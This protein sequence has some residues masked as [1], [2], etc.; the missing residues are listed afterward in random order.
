[1]AK[2]EYIQTAMDSKNGLTPEVKEKLRQKRISELKS[3][4]SQLEDQQ[5]KL[6]LT[7]IETSMLENQ[8]VIYSDVIDK[9]ECES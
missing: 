7:D 6:V 5:T 4:R 3:M 2:V 9:M 1:M 8:I